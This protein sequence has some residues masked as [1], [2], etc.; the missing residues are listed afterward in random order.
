MT[1]RLGAIGTLIHDRIWHPAAEGP[2]EQ[3]GGAAYSLA[4]LAAAHPPRWGVAPVLKVGADLWDE[5]SA[6]LAGLPGV[7]VG[8]G[9]RRVPEPNNR[10]ELRYHDPANRC[11][12]LTGGVPPWSGPELVDAVEGSSAIYVNF[13]SGMEMDLDAARALRA[14]S[15]GPIYADL[16]SLFLGPPGTGPRRPRALPHAEEWLA[17]FDAVQVNETELAL[18]GSSHDRLAALL[19]HGPSLVLVTRGGAG[20]SF[21]VRASRGTSPISDLLGDPDS[22]ARLAG[23]PATTGTLPT[24]AG[25]L[26]G[27]PTGCGDVW[28]ATCCAALLGG[29]KLRDAMLRAHLAAATKIRNPAVATLHVALASSNTSARV[30]P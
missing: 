23:A 30:L 27:D 16:H 13:V 5:A 4:A 7:R 21:A 25:E 22:R 19:R 26:A 11:E 28:G 14:S 20:A 29:A 9:V 6:W 1:E 3:L 17:C 15:G 10:V 8:D 18:L 12:T 2:V 24:P